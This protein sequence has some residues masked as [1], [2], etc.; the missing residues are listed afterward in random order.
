MWITLTWRGSY[1]GESLFPL[2]CLPELV[3]PSR[4]PASD[5]YA[6]AWIASYAVVLPATV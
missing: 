6:A 4:C 2:A 3:L 1:F 5:C